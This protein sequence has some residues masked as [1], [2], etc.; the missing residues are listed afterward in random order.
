M[1]PRKSSEPRARGINAVPAEVVFYAGRE[2]LRNAARH[3][4]RESAGSALRLT[5]SGR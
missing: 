3:A 1:C 5:V 2:A 4:R